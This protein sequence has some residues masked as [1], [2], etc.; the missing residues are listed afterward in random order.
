MSVTPMV[1]AGYYHTVALRADGT[2][3][4]WG[5][6]A[7]GQLGL[8]DVVTPRTT[9]Q[10]VG[11]STWLAGAAGGYNHTVA[12]RADG[13]LWTW[14]YNTYGQL[15]LGFAE[16]SP[17]RA[18]DARLA[19]GSAAGS[20]AAV[21]TLARG[22]ALAGTAAGTSSATA[23]VV[24]VAHPDYI[25]RVRLSCPVCRTVRLTTGIRRSVSL[26]CPVSLEEV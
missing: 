13:T 2:L 6:N 14:G 4:T 17:C 1:A 16:S 23:A 20:G 12:L 22:R 18:I 9:P 7:S 26:S 3:W 24:G 25:E 15:G 8:G 21:A 10:Q 19:S 5:Y 11:S